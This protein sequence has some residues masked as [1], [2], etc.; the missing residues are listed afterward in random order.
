MPASLGVAQETGADA[1]QQAPDSEVGERVELR[2]SLRDAIRMALEF[3]PRIRIAR[4]DENIRRRDIT[5]A[6]ST[7]DPYFNVNATYAKNRDPTVSVLDVGVIP[8]DEVALNPWESTIYSAGVSGLWIL[9]TQYDI[10]LSQLEYDR[11]ATSDAGIVALNPAARTEISAEL[12][13]PL[14]KGA[15]HDVNTSGIRIARNNALISREELE[16][17]A[18]ELVFRVEEAYW[19]VLF[20]RQN[21]EAKTNA[22]ELAEGYLENA[23]TKR[24]AGRMA[25]VDVTV[26][27]SQLALRN[28]ERESAHF[29]YTTSGDRLLNLINHSGDQTL[30]DRWEERPQEQPYGSMEVI[31]TTE[32]GPV[33]PPHDRGEA[34]ALAF[35][36]RPEYRRI[37]LDLTNQR[38]RADVARNALLPSLDVLARWTQLGLE[39]DF[40]ESFNSVDS[41]RFYDWFVGVEFSVP[42]SNRGNRNR[43]RNVRDEVRKLELERDDLENRIVL[44]IDAVLSEIASLRQRSADLD[45]RVRLQ[46]SIVAV[47]RQKLEVGRTIAHTVSTIENE[48]MRNRT[49]ALKTRADLQTARARFLKASGTLLDSHQI[50][51]AGD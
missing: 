46:E 12:R 33:L 27:E 26:A 14:L 3:N 28:V 10:R 48:L 45:E 17:S 36:R 44:E 42:L 11:K 25:P 2:L 21:L 49:E 20:A 7:F 41:G 22:V 35:A 13:Q 4:L 39:E 23:R 16:R 38:I 30:R 29:L 18:V 9:G 6:R 47:E 31:C 15:W 5:I 51:L 50:E 40:G 1:A 43:Y 32:P 34:V 24:A 37:L 19:N 8:P